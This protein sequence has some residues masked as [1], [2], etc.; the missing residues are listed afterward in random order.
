ML[1]PVIGTIASGVIVTAAF[2]YM[3]HSHGK[4]VKELTEDFAN[5]RRTLIN[6]ILSGTT[7]EFIARQRASEAP[8]YPVTKAAD[9]VGHQLDI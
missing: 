7:G 5:E 1:D 9:P 3:G 8:A 2:S 6:H 4:Q